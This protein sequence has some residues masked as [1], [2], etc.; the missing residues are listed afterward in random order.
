LLHGPSF[1]CRLCRRNSTTGGK[2]IGA[3]PNLN[4]K[5][6]NNFFTKIWRF[7]IS[8]LKARVRFDRKDCYVQRRFK[9]PLTLDTSTKRCLR[10]KHLNARLHFRIL[11]VGVSPLNDLLVD[12]LPHRKRWDCPVLKYSLVEKWQ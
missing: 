6:P 1:F 2:Y 12:Q 5:E 4:A 9:E 10:P 3:K 11:S 8:R 7:I